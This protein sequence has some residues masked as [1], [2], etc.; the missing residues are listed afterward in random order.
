MDTI[1]LVVSW[2][3]FM[4]PAH[5][6]QVR[7]MPDLDT[8]LAKAAALTLEVTDLEQKGVQAKL[9]ARCVKVPVTASL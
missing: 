7:N 3:L 2:T 8:C 4:P 9:V 1:I 6:V 5:D